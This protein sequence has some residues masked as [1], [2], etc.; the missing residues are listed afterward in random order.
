MAK[1]KMY[2]GFIGGWQLNL[3]CKGKHFYY[4]GSMVTLNIILS[5]TNFG[6]ASREL[7]DFLALLFGCILKTILSTHLS[8][9]MFIGFSLC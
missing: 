2:I 4:M 3:I 6:S 5:K 8:F 9:M 1:I 7:L